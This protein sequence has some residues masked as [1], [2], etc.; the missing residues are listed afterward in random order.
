[1]TLWEIYQ[2]RAPGETSTEKRSDCSP[3]FWFIP[4]CKV[5]LTCNTF[6]HDHP[7]VDVDDFTAD[8][9]PKAPDSHT[10]APLPSEWSPVQDIA[11]SIHGGGFYN[12]PRF[13]IWLMCIWGH[14]CHSFWTTCSSVGPAKE[15]RIHL[16]SPPT[17]FDQ[18]LPS[19]IHPTCPPEP[20]PIIIIT[21][22]FWKMGCL[23]NSKTE[24]QRNE[25]KAQREANKK[26]EKQLQKDKQIYRA[27]HRLLL[28]G[29]FC[30]LYCLCSR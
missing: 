15:F 10:A 25:E 7:R 4:P 24:D 29:G 8:F 26:I 2:G 22:L 9:H 5:A 20:H 18:Q 17:P 30:L 21:S 23:G 27:T 28:L 6:I 16:P 12:P 3:N 11:T 1:M 14:K 19:P 13:H